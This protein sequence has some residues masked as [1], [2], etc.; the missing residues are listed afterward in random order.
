MHT[1]FEWLYFYCV[2]LLNT[3]LWCTNSL[4]VRRLCIL[5][6]LISWLSNETVV[7]WT[8][9]A[10]LSAF[11]FF[12]AITELYLFYA[13]GFSFS[14]CHDV[15]FSRLSFFV[16]LHVVMYDANVCKGCG[17]CKLDFVKGW[18]YVDLVYECIGDY[19]SKDPLFKH[20]GVNTKKKHFLNT[21]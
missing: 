5:Q 9:I 13:G 11:L 14:W 17:N 20:L 6:Y 1:Y 2:K 21:N 15:Y 8:A 7:H 10:V 4:R 16:Y 18:S 19:F 12:A 3:W